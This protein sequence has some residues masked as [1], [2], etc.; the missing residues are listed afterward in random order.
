VVLEADFDVWRAAAREALHAGYRPE[1][2]E[3]EDGTVPAPLNLALETD[4]APHGERMEHPR[5][6][7]QFLEVAQVAAVHRD[8]ERWNL[9]YR[10][11]YRLQGEADLLKIE[12][13]DDVTEL[14][15]L[16]AQVQRDLH[17]MHAFVR[18]RKVMAPGTPGERPVV[19]DEP[20]LVGAGEGDEHHLVL[21]TPTP[22][23]PVEREIEGCAADS[24]LGVGSNP[25]AEDCEH[26][27]AWYQPD[28][29]ILPM[30]AP[31]FAERFA[32]MR[33]TILTPDAS[34]TWD[35]GRKKLT[36][37]AGVPRES[38]PAEDE[39]EALWRSYYASIYNPARLNTGA[40]RNE[41]PVRYWKNLPEVTLLPALIAGSKARVTGMVMKQQQASTAQPFVP[42]EHNLKAISA[43]LPE[44]KG[45]EL[46][47]FATQPVPGRGA[48]KAALMLVGEQP[49]DQEDRQGEPFVGPAG[50][51][52]DKLLEELQIPRNAIFV[53]NAVKHFKFI[54]RGKLR[55]HQNPR[56]SEITACRPWLLAEIDAV[57][58]KV[59]L[60]LG[61][62]AS[63]SLLGGTFALMK[64][65]GK[66][67]ATPY[68][69]KVV[70]TIHP[71]AV[72]RARDEESRH[73]LRQ[74]LADD[75]AMAW[76]TSLG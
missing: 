40:M 16:K 62:S 65:H 75:L 6:T 57:K 18:F 32:I 68:A 64:D 43:A 23:G 38:A 59:V 72:L 8:P 73:K 9:L 39:L 14:L 36:F 74:F 26:F 22:F 27:V 66:V 12:T 61:A 5:V 29:R 48:S 1:D 53:T 58:P 50:G 10:I 20:V 49:G 45:C 7:K 69:D 33:W 25:G 71:S 41:M 52:L 35:P 76:K 15:R 70:A 2:I 21:Q 11:L 67:L 54:Q 30:A 51:V 31:F 13:D 17:K 37:G 4:E 46:Y 55:L 3:F 34:V 47:C 19:V 44:C 28:H 42:E 24:A 60:C 56:M 63:K